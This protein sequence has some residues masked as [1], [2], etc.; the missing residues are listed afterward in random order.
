MSNDN[1]KTPEERT[2]LHYGRSRNGDSI[3]VNTTLE[4]RV[5][6]SLIERNF[7]EIIRYPV[8]LGEKEVRILVSQLQAWL[9]D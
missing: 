3:L 1:E 4:Q 6:M 2:E 8:S 9:G 5:S 7:Q